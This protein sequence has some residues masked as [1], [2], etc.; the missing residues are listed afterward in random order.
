MSDRG[1]DQGVR[2]FIH[3]GSESVFS[4]NPRPYGPEPLCS[5]KLKGTCQIEP[6]LQSPKMVC[7][8]QWSRIL[9][10]MLPCKEPKWN[11][12]QFCGNVSRA[13]SENGKRIFVFRFRYSRRYRLLRTGAQLA[14]RPTA[15]PSNQ[16]FQKASIA[17][18]NPSPSPHRRL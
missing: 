12:P 17:H 9:S 15:L 6:S 2:G 13:R 3:S 7:T 4:R 10:G 14:R 5:P 16:S 1:A 18:D 8:P 11:M